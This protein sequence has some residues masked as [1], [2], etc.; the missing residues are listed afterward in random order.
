MSDRQR[1]TSRPATRRRGASATRILFGWRCGL[2]ERCR[3]Q[4]AAA[5]SSGQQWAAGS[6]E[7]RA[8]AGSSG[9]QRAAAGSSGQQR[10][11]A[12]SGQR[13]AGSSG[14]QTLPASARA[15][16]WPSAAR[17]LAAPS[18][19]SG[20]RRLT[21]CQA[22]VATRGTAHAARRRGRHRRRVSTPCGTAR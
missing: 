19:S 8:T 12:G 16:K 14:A 22:G 1:H 15:C 20:G 2:L 17:A 5:G 3:G 7:Q 6:S 10:A 21:A 13:A 18:A 9:Q 11:A 4:Q